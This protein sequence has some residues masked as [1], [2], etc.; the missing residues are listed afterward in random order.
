[1]KDLSYEFGIRRLVKK[2][3]K[4]RRMEHHNVMVYLD[5]VIT[6]YW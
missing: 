3:H 4:L 2:F 1:M 6:L 5:I